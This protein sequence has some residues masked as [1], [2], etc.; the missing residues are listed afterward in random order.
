M[1]NNSDDG[2]ASDNVG[3]PPPDIF[4]RCEG[5]IFLFEPRT[6]AAKQWITENVQPDAQWFGNALVVEGRYAAE[7]AAGMRDAGLALS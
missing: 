1:G 3:K 5:T 2:P 4:V 6:V 7:L